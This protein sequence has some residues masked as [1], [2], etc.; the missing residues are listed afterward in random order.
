MNHDPSGLYARLGVDPEAPPEA[1]GAAYRRKARILHPDVPET[2]DAE[3]FIQVKQAYD[4]LSD[5]GRRAAYDRA[6]GTSLPAAPRTEEP[7]PHGPRLSDLPIGLWAGLGC[8]FCLAAVMAVVQFNRP[9]LSPQRPVIRPFAPSVPAV[10]P[11]PPTQMVATASGPTTHYVL[12][13]GNDTVVWRHDVERDAYLPA[14]HIAAFSP[15]RA[16]SLVSQHGLVEIGLADGG[17]GFIDA[18]RLAPGDRAAAHRADCAY[19]AGPSPRNGE[20]LARHGVGT[21]R[22][23]ISNRAAQPAVVKL[24]DASGQAA[25]TV[26]VAPGDSA[27]VANLPNTVYRLDFALGELWSRSCNSFAAGMRAQRFPGYLTP[28][29]KSPLVIPPDLSVAPAP[30]DIPDAAFERE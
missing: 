13:A 11:P 16:L 19:N 5:A 30:V 29:G 24:R 9:R 2:G 15:V 8:L 28:S 27:I 26:F 3:A 6:G 17:S 10:R 14:G 18:L 25:A 12:P 1:I 4:V 23:A 21:A 7:T 22:V 20:V